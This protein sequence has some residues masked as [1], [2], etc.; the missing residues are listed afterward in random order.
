MSTRK[1]LIYLPLG[2]AGEI[3][4]NMYLYGYGCPGSEEFILIDVGVSFP[5]LDRSPGVDLIIPDTKFIEKNINRLRGIFITHGHEDHIGALGHVWD[6]IKAPIYCREFTGIIAENKLNKIGETKQ[7]ITVVDT[8]PKMIKSGPFKVGFV[9]VS[10]SIPEASSLVIDTPNGRVIHTG[11]FKIDEQPALGDSFNEGLFNEIKKPG[12]LATIC[13]STNVFSEN[14][15]RSE[16]A[17]K[18]NVYNLIKSQKGIVVATTFASNI[19]R[20]LTLAECAHAAGRKILILGRAMQSMVAMAKSVG[21]L[22]SLPPIISIDQISEISRSKLFIIV[23]GSQG[24]SRAVSAQLAKQSYMGVELKSNDCFLFSS[25]TIPGNEI[26]VSEVINNLVK[27]GVNVID[28]SS[29]LYHVSGHANRPDLE[30]LHHLFKPKLVIPMHGEDR[31]V[32]KH[33]NLAKEIGYNTVNVTNGS[34]LE[35]M[36]TGKAKIVEE[37]EHGRQYLDGGKLINSRAGVVKTRLQLASWG[38]VSVSVLLEEDKVLENGIWVK[39]KG[40]P[41]IDEELFYLESD[42]E[43]SLTKGLYEL[44]RYLLSDDTYLEGIIQ[45]IVNKICKKAF[46]KKPVTTIFINRLS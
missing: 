46:Y 43:K 16:T 3:G 34:V 45:R 12:I 33:S 2:G 22:K 44:E 7:K 13:D 27:K 28:D 30:R 40:L 25:K 11:D 4:M 6:R 14:Q 24:E 32:W 42:L 21:F 39:T 1:R 9:P 10:H 41:F 23:T 5:S 37:V 35:I 38:H 19:A 8:F 17:I 29:G 31:H 20:V 36:K 15:G 26:A 18:K